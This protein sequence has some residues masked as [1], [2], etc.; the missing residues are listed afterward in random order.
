MRIGV[1][2]GRAGVSPSRIRFYEGQGLL[3][4]AARLA[5]GYRDY[6]ERDLEIVRFINRARELG[7]SLAEIAAHL[8]SPHDNTRKTRL[9]SKVEAKISELDALVADLQ[10][11]RQILMDLAAE[12]RGHAAQEH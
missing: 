12:L 8:D 7:F 11:R 3:P 4:R 6:D 10:F 2:A 9:L 1:F 5:S